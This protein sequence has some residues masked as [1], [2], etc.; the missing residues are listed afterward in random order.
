MPAGAQ[1]CARQAVRSMRKA[2]TTEV[3]VLVT[4]SI[5]PIWSSRRVEP[6]GRFGAQQRDVV[7]LAAHRAEL[8][9]LGQTGQAPRH[10]LCGF[11]A[12]GDAHIGL[13]GT[14]A[15]RPGPAARCSRRSPPRAPAAPAGRAPWC[16]PH[17]A[18]APG[19]PC[20]RGRWPAAARESAVE[21]V[22]RHDRLCRIARRN[23][24]TGRCLRRI[25]AFFRRLPIPRLVSQHPGVDHAHHPARRRPHRPDH[26]PPARGQRRLHR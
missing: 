20:C 13:H 18:C 21:V 2:S 6:R 10:V 11:R 26:R 25:Q 19:W 23:V 5:S 8:A 14:L 15:P 16:A 12:D 1:R 4:P 24:R 22:A 9:Q 17:R 3:V 7:E